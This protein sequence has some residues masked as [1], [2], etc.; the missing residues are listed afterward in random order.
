M[1]V[2]LNQSPTHV[3]RSRHQ[4]AIFSVIGIV[5]VG[6]AVGMLFEV[7]KASV[8]LLLV[9]FLVLWIPCN[10]RLALSGV[11]TGEKGVRVANLLSSFEL[12]WAEIEEFEIG[13][14][15]IFP[16]VGL[17]RLRSGEQKHALGIQERTN[18][19]DGSGEEMVN[20]LNGEVRERLERFPTDSGPGAAQSESPSAVMNSHT[21]ETAA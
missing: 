1:P 6:I 4:V 18:F 17:I 11:F 5:G 9:A 7:K 19:P 8:L 3:Y 10:I 12:E 14:W 15:A 16:Y 2:M 13:R 20:E 21:Q